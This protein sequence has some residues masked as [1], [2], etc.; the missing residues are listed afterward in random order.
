MF[1]RVDPLD[2]MHAQILLNK[3]D[4]L[5]HTKE[6]KRIPLGLKV[7]FMHL[8]GKERKLCV[9]FSSFLGSFSLASSE[10]TVGHGPYYF[11]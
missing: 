5:L 11:G 2:R 6:L 9:T 10:H 8:E 4:S 7:K 1:L 3:E